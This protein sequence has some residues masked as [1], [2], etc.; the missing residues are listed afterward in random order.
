MPHAPEIEG[1]PPTCVGRWTQIGGKRVEPGGEPMRLV[2]ALRGLGLE[3][4][5]QQQGRW[6]TLQGERCHVYVIEA[7]WGTGYA[8]WCDAPG[9]RTV[10]WY[11]DP[12][13]AIVAGLR[14]AAASPT[15]LPHAPP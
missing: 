10:E 15:P 14:R 2:D 12:A 5:V 6:I 11:D 9:Q 1:Q 13:Q 3:G 4:D 8:T 7:D